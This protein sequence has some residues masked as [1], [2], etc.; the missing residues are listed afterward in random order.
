MLFV[1]CL[2]AV[3][4][5][6]L[7]SVA[8]LMEGRLL[9]RDVPLSG[10]IVWLCVA[11][12]SLAQIPFPR[13][14]GVLHRDADAVTAGHQRWRLL[15]SVVVQDGGVIGTV[16]NLVLLALAL[17]ICLRLWGSVATISTF[18]VAGLGLNI[19]AVRFGAT[20]GGGNSGAT[21]PLL[22]SLPPYALAVLPPGKRS[23]AAIGCLIMGVSALILVIAKDGHGIAVGFGLVIGLAGMPFARRR[24]SRRLSLCHTAGV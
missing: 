1:L 16:S 14:Y 5:A 10:W 20:D 24:W 21:L 4:A 11:V 13:V 18:V 22:A 7:Q 3:V 17:V 9:W 23:R 12:P 6:A 19:L 2:V 15:T 8:P